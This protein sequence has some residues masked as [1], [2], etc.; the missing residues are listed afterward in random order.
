MARIA[1]TRASDDWLSCTI[2]TVEAVLEQHG[3]VENPVPQI[4]L[5]AEESTATWDKLLR[6]F[7][8]LRLS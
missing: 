6:T 4:N 2:R 3:F 1:M 8:L 5:A 7:N